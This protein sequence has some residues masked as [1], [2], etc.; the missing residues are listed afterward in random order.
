MR[1]YALRFV[2]ILF[3]SLPSCWSQQA[4]TVCMSNIIQPGTAKIVKQLQD[5]NAVADAQ[6]KQD[7][8]NDARNLFSM[9]LNDIGNM[10]ACTAGQQ[11]A[12]KF[13]G[14]LQL[15]STDKQVGASTG[16]SGS[17]NLVPSGS[18][19]ALLGLAVE[20]GGLTETFSGTTATFRTT[21]AK[22]IGAM[23]DT[24]GT[25]AK[26]TENKS[27]L[28][29]QRLSLSASFTT[30]GTTSA[31]TNNASQ[32]QAN[33]SQFTQATARFLIWND[34]DPLA[35]KNWKTIRDLSTSPPAQQDADAARAL[36]FPI[37]DIPGF[38]AAI[39]QAMTVFDAN[40]ANP[41][42][43]TL[44]NAWIACYASIQKLTGQVQNWQTLMNN[45]IAAR[46]TLEK[47]TQTLYQKISKA[48]SLSLE[49]DYTRPP[50]VTATSTSASTTPS[51]P[52]FSPNLSTLSLV[53]VASVSTSDFTLN[54]TA[55]FFNQTEP[56]MSGN[57]RDFQLAGKWDIP[58]GHIGSFISKGTLTISGLFEDLHQ[59]PLGVT[60]TI[61]D[62]SVNTPGN[63]GVFQIKYTIPMGD[64]GVQVPISFTTSNRTELVNEKDTRGNIGITFDLDKLLATK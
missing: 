38:N 50:A 37:R 48:P 7:A 58:V 27:L 25:N 55:N 28:A 20:Y 31:S 40:A 12:D 22:L 9:Y 16:T 23:T 10:A 5:A 4:S 29:M 19:P 62:K 43:T 56:T 13:A 60:L 34:R 32:L 63:M 39:D 57:F 51:A 15:R 30:S 49:Y 52:A 61:N 42:Q 14:F 17:T 64:S 3:V 59:K 35:A 46:T 47:Q 53:Y 36:F 54:A 24:Y 6:K 1:S 45:Y 41:N 2:L 26:P 44:Q 21:P 11:I 8:R 18:V 33:P